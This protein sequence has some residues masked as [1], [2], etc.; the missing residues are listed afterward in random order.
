M[1][2]ISFKIEDDFREE[3]EAKVE[4]M[5]TDL[6]TFCRDAIRSYLSDRQKQMDAIPEDLR[7]RINF[8]IQIALTG[9]LNKDWAIIREEAIGL[10]RCINQGQ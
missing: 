3:I 1:K 9:N 7:N 5:S 4:E 10:C 2:S 8:L 6:S